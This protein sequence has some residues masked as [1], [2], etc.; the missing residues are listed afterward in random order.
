MSDVGRSTLFARQQN[1]ELAAEAREMSRA[2]ADF[3]YLGW[4]TGKRDPERAWD[5]YFA[6]TQPQVR[7][8]LD[9]ILKSVPPEHRGAAERLA[10][11]VEAFCLPS[12]AVE[13][14]VLENPGGSGGHLIGI[15]P[16]V[17]QLSAEIAWNMSSAHPYIPD[18]LPEGWQMAT[19][20]AQESFALT[21]HQYV[22][23]LERFGDV[24]KPFGMLTAAVQVEGKSGRPGG[25]PGSG[26]RDYYDVRDEQ[27]RVPSRI[28]LGDPGPDASV[29]QGALKGRAGHVAPTPVRVRGVGRCETGFEH[30]T[31]DV[32]RRLGS[33]LGHDLVVRD[34][35]LVGP[36]AVVLGRVPRQ[37]PVLLEEFPESLLR[38]Y[39]E[40]N[41]DDIAVRRKRQHVQLR[42][43]MGPQHRAQR[44]AEAADEAFPQR[45]RPG[46]RR[47]VVHRSHHSPPRTRSR[48][49]VK[50]VA[51]G[52]TTLP[53]CHTPCAHTPGFNRHRPLPPAAH[54]WRRTST[55]RKR[56]DTKAPSDRAALAAGLPPLPWKSEN[57]AVW[58]T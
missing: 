52:V 53:R 14:R 2:F 19:L 29:T 7:A 40:A 21:V 9:G 54:A 56:L 20:H 32:D 1:P 41:R 36:P 4:V 26:T 48:P 12:N 23:T 50:G 10:G 27:D 42:S 28:Q 11:S 5:G 18:A 15:S 58:L 57:A 43:R 16:L 13:S 49:H 33:V 51:W 46:P 6:H 37:L 45:E 47:S 17:V 44:R 22:R 8:V 38:V 39:R 25:L 30:G 35:P 3:S 31:G 55:V 24:P 34:L